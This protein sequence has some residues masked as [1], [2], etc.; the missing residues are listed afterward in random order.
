MISIDT[1][2]SLDIRDSVRG[3]L[4]TVMAQPRRAALLAYLAIEGRGDFV[5][6][7]SL[8]ALLWPDYD[9][10]R[11]RAALRQALTFLRRAIGEQALLSRGDDAIA[12]DVG[13]MSCDLWDFHAALNEG[14]D[15]QAL[16]LYRGRL[17]DGLVVGDALAFEQ[18]VSARRV[19]LVREA[20]GAAA[21]RAD[22][23]ADQGDLVRAIERARDAERIEPFNESHHR[24]LL[25]LLDRAGDRSGALLEHDAF[26][27]RLLAALDVEPAP[28]TRALVASLRGRT[29]VRLSVTAA[30][31]TPSTDEAS[32]VPIGAPVPETG[33]TLPPLPP[34]GRVRIWPVVAA[35]AVIVSAVVMAVRQRDPAAPTLTAASTGP[36]A[37]RI[38]VLPLTDPAGDS[39]RIGVMAADW[40][41]EGLSR[42]DDIEVVPA[43][44]LLATEAALATAPSAPAS[45]RWQ[46]LAS[47]VGAGTV[48]RGAVYRDGRTI[49]L[50]AQV[51]ETRTGRLL[52]PV[53]RV[54]IPD[55]SVMLGIDRLR[56]RVV[57]AIAPLADT[58]THLRRAIAPPTYEAYRDYVAGLAAFVR[59]DPRAALSLFERSAGADSAYPMPRIAATIMRLNLDDADGAQRLI[60]TLN[61]ERARL[62]PL[63]LSTLD[64]VQGL[65]TGN[66]AFAYDAVVRQARIA[67]GTISEYMI[68]ELARKMNRPAEA[69]NVLRAL[70]PDRGELRGW[71]PYWRELTFALHLL[72]RHDEEL[73]AARDAM[74]RYP[75]DVTIA[76]YELRALAAL[77]DVRAVVTALARLDGSVASV[78][79]RAALRVTTATEFLAH[80]PDV[81]G[82]IAR[83]VTAWFDS[84]PSTERDDP[85][86]RR[87]DARALLLS[88]RAHDAHRRLQPLTTRMNAPATMSLALMGLA[89]NVA[90]AD[91]DSA[92]ARRWMRLLAAREQAMTT[93]AR[94]LTWGESPYWRAT[95]AARLSDSAAVLSLLREARRQG[96]AMEPAVHAEP[97][98]ASMR[99][100][101]P[102]AVIISP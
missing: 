31:D 91:G 14:R 68:G 84:M 20:A 11:A 55:D 76:A 67:P 22:Q 99:R 102:L 47:D 29:A 56:T 42:L 70:G 7:D 35:A 85:A 79:E 81:G 101:P 97:A 83:D 33:K 98:F 23:L 26:T 1:L 16:A 48:V 96:L 46:Q 8:L 71:R 87:H 64:M 73:V 39:L 6:R 58:V 34:A 10:H 78:A 54:S 15:E 18:W 41:T 80:H 3:R 62:G 88:G 45:E 69:V 43:M 4:A 44:A 92:A 94:G 50:Q 49:H 75:N 89:G 52:R 72:G 65:M 95:I 86:I 51:L 30:S 24:R 36:V 37:S 2:G 19:S 60:A 13:H 9:E 53:E 5:S 21:R 59:G 74:R 28:E 40:I 90:A 12:V 27:A 77:G 57:A 38:A 17:L 82:D 100:W 32:A 93:A 25:T 61:D 63:E 66:L